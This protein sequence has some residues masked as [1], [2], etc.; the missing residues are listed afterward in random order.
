MSEPNVQEPTM[1][2]IL[3]SIR[4]IISED[5]PAAEA[6][7]AEAPAPEP[8]AAEAMPTV[9]AEEVLEL[10]NPLPEPEPVETHGDLEVHQA[11][12]EPEPEPMP[13]PVAAA[14]AY[15]EPLVSDPTADQTASAFGHLARSIAM[16]RAGRNL[17]DVVAELLRPLLKAWL[18]EHLPTIVQAKVE[19]EVERIARRRVG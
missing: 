19:E 11:E 1:E 9:E 2:E 3:A 14:A 12:P 16:P 18:D 6:A 15:D 4:R 13:E 17:E 10:T 5:E 7:P 8:M